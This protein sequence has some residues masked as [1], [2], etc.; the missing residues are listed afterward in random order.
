MADTPNS[1]PTPVSALP[2]ASSH[3][4][5][6]WKSQWGFQVATDSRCY[7]IRESGGSIIAAFIFSVAIS[8]SA[9]WL[10]VSVFVSETP[11]TLGEKGFGVLMF[12]IAAAFLAILYF[13][14]KRGR[15]MVVF[16][17]GDAASGTLGEVR[18]QGGKRLSVERVRS[19]STRFCGGSPPRSTVVAELHDGT[20]ASLGPV[21]IQSWAAHYAQQ[22]ATWMGL[23]FRPGT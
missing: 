4:R 3:G 8:V 14:L 11:T 2:P 21:E 17:R 13:S 15:W 10:G 23:P 16:D 5:L 20:H 18:Y 6:K 12:F 9:A 7:Y 22:A 1:T 19:F